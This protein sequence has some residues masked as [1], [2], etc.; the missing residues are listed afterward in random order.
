VTAAEASRRLTVILSAGLVVVIALG[1][2]LGVLLGR[3]EIQPV[4]PATDAPTTV[5]TNTGSVDAPDMTPP[6]DGGPRPEPAATTTDPTVAP[7]TPADTPADTTEPDSTPSTSGSVSTAPDDTTVTI[8][9][10]ATG[11]GGAD[12][13]GSAGRTTGSDGSNNTDS[14]S[15]TDTDT[16]TDTD[17]EGAGAGEPTSAAPPVG[18]EAAGN[19][20]PAGAGVAPTPADPDQ[21]ETSPAA[22]IEADPATAGR[23]A[24]VPV[25]G[26]AADEVDER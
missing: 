20:A 23:A 12:D 17:I 8:T 15:D 18:D 11:P 3:R 16:D 22:L 1:I 2:A 26:T 5:G 10:T 7:T 14:D 21:D 13:P 4:A 19:D 9:S 24:Q 25:A 6:G